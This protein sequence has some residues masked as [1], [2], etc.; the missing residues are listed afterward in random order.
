MCTQPAAAEQTSHDNHTSS[1]RCTITT[2]VCHP[3]LSDGDRK[4]QFI[5]YSSITTMTMS[6]PAACFLITSH[7]K[8]N[9][10]LPNQISDSLHNLIGWHGWLS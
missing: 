5:H 2:F 9:T 4:L 6:D 8:C 3:L 7:Y 1:S 10:M